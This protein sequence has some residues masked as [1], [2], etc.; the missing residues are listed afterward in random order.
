MSPPYIVRCKQLEKEIEELSAGMSQAIGS[1]DHIPSRADY[2]N[3]RDDLA[4]R[5]VNGLIIVLYILLSISITPE[6]VL[7]IINI[8]FII[9]GELDKSRQTLEGLKREHGQLNANLDKVNINEW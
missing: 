8:W 4:F 3:M 2:L 5:E 6:K 7:F 1:V 9:Q